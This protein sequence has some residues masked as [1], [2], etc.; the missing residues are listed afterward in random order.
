[1]YDFLFKTWAEWAVLPLAILEPILLYRTSK[2]TQNSRAFK[3]V[4]Q[5]HLTFLFD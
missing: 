5:P 2:Y 1:M 4:C 3:A